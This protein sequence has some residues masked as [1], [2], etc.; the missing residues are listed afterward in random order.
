MINSWLYHRGAS[1]GLLCPFDQPGRSLRLAALARASAER[2]RPRAQTRREVRCRRLGLHRGPTARSRKYSNAFQARLA[3]CSGRVD[4]STAGA[5][6]AGERWQGLARPLQF[7]VAGHH[8]GLAN[9][10]EEEQSRRSSLRDRL[11][12][13][14]LD[15]SAYARDIELAT[16]LSPLRLAPHKDAGG[17]SDRA[18]FQAAFFTRML[19]SVWSMPT[20]WIPKR[21][22]SGSRRGRRGG[23]LRPFSLS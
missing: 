5:V 23:W 17:R 12:A 2:G 7:V 3:G 18:G 10:G 16:A 13:A 19:F 9:G 4:H 21:S 11:A 14:V 1:K 8:A 22:T 15:Y 6:E 20:S